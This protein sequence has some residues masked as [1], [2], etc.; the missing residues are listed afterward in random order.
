[1]KKQGGFSHRR[2]VDDTMLII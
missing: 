2:C 1:M